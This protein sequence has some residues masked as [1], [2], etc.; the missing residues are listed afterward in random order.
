M[1][2]YTLKR[3]KWNTRQCYGNATSFVLI[4]L[5]FFFFLTTRTKMKIYIEN[6]RIL[7]C[8]YKWQFLFPFLYFFSL[9]KPKKCIIIHIFFL[10]HFPS[11]QIY[12]QEVKKKKERNKATRDLIMWNLNVEGFISRQFLA[13]IHLDCGISSTPFPPKKLDGR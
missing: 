7:I 12:Y 4:A 3:L 9:I 10:H 11:I 13:N 8:F 5:S 2:V 1:K 6:I